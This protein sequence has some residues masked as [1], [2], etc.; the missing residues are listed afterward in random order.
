[1]GDR[2]G[3][4]RLNPDPQ[5]GRPTSKP[6]PPSTPTAKPNLTPPAPPAPTNPTQPNLAPSSSSRE[7]VWNAIDKR[8]TKAQLDLNAIGTAILTLDF[9]TIE[10]EVTFRA[11]MRLLAAMLYGGNRIVQ[12]GLYKFFHAVHNEIFFTEI[13]SR[14]VRDVTVAEHRICTL[15]SRRNTTDGTGCRHTCSSR[16]RRRS[17]RRARSS[18]R[19]QPSAR[20]VKRY[21]RK[22]G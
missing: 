7:S 1:M 19:W 22:E 15:C 4:P 6:N 17:A 3:R 21:E 9:M 12:Q 18:R 11:A 14:L 16:R 8:V 20:T 13:R 2:P 10:D 5:S